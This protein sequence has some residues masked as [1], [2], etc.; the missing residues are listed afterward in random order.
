MSKNIFLFTK[1]IILMI[2]PITY[3]HGGNI[4]TNL[5]L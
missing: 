1:Y 3:V 4:N 2:N 5:D